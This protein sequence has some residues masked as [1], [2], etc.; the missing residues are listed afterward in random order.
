MLTCQ[1][2]NLLLTVGSE[3]PGVSSST[4]KIWECNKLEALALSLGSVSSPSLDPP[5][6]D[7]TRSDSSGGGANQTAPVLAAPV[8]ALLRWSKVFSAPR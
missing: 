6:A 1:E 3:E 7:E 2:G 4:L 5:V 8:G